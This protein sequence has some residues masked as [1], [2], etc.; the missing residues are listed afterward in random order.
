MDALAPLAQLAV[1]L[2]L[3]LRDR[4]VGIPAGRPDCRKKRRVL[5]QRDAFH[6]E[7]QRCARVRGL[8]ALVNIDMGLE[9]GATAVTVQL[10]RCLHGVVQA[11]TEY[12]QLPQTGEI[13]QLVSAVE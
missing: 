5:C 2:I 4:L 1:D 11:I 8:L 12:M 13:R 6:G 3:K 10:P 9:S 7:R